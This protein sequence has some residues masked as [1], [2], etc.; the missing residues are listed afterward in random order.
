MQSDMSREAL[1]R[2]RG[3]IAE[4]LASG[5][6]DAG[7]RL[8][9]EREFALRLGTTRSAVRHALS[10]LEIEQ[11]VIRHVGRGT[12]VAAPR[13]DDD[14]KPARPAADGWIPADASPAEL[15]EARQLLEPLVAEAVVLNANEA[16]L[17]IL[18]AIVAAQ[19]AADEA[20]GFEESDIAL[21]RAL[22]EATHNRLLVAVSRLILASRQSPEWRKLKAAVARWKTSRRAEAVREHRRIVD[23]LSERNAA[24]AHR[25]MRDHLEQ[26]R[27]NLLGS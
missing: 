23:A 22:A 21:H 3:F 27:R 7:Q 14:G 5:E 15:M 19:E 12:F 24:G 1:R 8:P 18:H 26:V 2:V 13:P 9:A 25:A 4:G 10:V 17:R 20:E 6:I 11:R 16:D